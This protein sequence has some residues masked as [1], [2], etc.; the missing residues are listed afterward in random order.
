[1]VHAPIYF[2]K[3]IQNA[4][5]ELCLHLYEIR[6]IWNVQAY[7]LPWLRDLGPCS[8][9]VILDAALFDNKGYSL[10]ERVVHFF[11]I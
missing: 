8:I 6:H 11:M 10:Y 5:K 3:F 7:R 2:G 1:M 9:I 4:I